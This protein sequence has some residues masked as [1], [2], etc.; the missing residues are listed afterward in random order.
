MSYLYGIIADVLINFGCFGMFLNNVFCPIVWYT[1]WS[2]ARCVSPHISRHIFVIWYKTIA[3]M[4]RKPQHVGNISSDFPYMLRFLSHLCNGFHINDKNVARRKCVETHFAL[5]G[6]VHNTMGQNT[7]FKNMRLSQAIVTCYCSVEILGQK[8][9]R[10]NVLKRLF[11]LHIS[12]VLCDRSINNVIMTQ[13][14]NTTAQYPTGLQ[15][16]Q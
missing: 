5:L 15:I 6:F 3:K 14:N 13:R 10:L 4:R 11:C 8:F 2:W 12:L 1:D 9:I 7:L 16:V